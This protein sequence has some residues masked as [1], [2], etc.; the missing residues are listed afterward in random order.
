MTTINKS[1]V[2]THGRFALFRL[3]NHSRV[4]GSSIRFLLGPP[5]R[6]A[7]ML[8]K[9]AFLWSFQKDWNQSRFLYSVDGELQISWDPHHITPLISP[10]AHH[11]GG[12]G[13]NSKNSPV[14]TLCCCC[15]FFCTCSNN[16]SA[17]GNHPYGKAG[18]LT[19]MYLGAISGRWEQYL[20]DKK[21]L[22]AYQA[23]GV[24]IHR[25]SEKPFQTWIYL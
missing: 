24:P 16:A 15:K 2:I 21:C 12:G 22:G 8:F 19:Q 10:C 4:F 3:S 11:S 13:E 20:T 23:T 9:S 17:T 7:L 25:S 1:G 14:W 18:Q 5:P 6:F